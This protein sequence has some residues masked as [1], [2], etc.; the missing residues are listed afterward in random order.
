MGHTRFFWAHPTTQPWQP[1][2]D[3]LR[4]FCHKCTECQFYPDQV[5]QHSAMS[6]LKN[7]FGFFDQD[8]ISSV[9]RWYLLL[10]CLKSNHFWQNFN[11]W[12]FD[13]K[14]QVSSQC[15][16]LG[17][18]A[19][20]AMLK[21]ICLW[22]FEKC[23]IYS[24]NRNFVENSNLESPI[25]TS[26]RSMKFLTFFG[27]L[28]LH[29]N[30][31]IWPRCEKSLNYSNFQRFLSHFTHKSILEYISTVHGVNDRSLRPMWR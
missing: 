11:F 19:F 14:S 24:G 16:L 22:M 13:T 6:G 7:I 23:H 8:V 10:I 18:L 30:T 15:D 20:L 9:E 4:L 17:K 12:N 31:V 3:V 26:L 2:K 27:S 28:I 29:F 21:S 1:Q 25:C 5:T